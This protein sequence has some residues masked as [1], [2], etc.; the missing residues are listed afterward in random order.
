MYQSKISNLIIKL[1]KAKNDDP[2]MTLQKICD[3][4]GVSMSTIQRI[5]ADNSENQSFRYE[6][7][8]PI[9]FLLLGTDGLEN[10]MDSDELQMQVAEI[11]DKYEKKLEKE[12]EQHRKSITFLM[13]QIDL[14]DDRITF[15]LNALEDRVQQ[16][17]ILKSQYDELMAQVLGKES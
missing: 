8:K 16:Y 11:K 2:E 13:K 12:R 10:N 9:S 3:S 17:K 1:K 7:L 5:F 14:K 15:L 6:S 4:T